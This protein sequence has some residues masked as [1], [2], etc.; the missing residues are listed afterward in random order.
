VDGHRPG[1][2]GGDPSGQ[3][4]DLEQVVR[5]TAHQRGV[6]PSLSSVGLLMSGGMVWPDLSKVVPSL[7]GESS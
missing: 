7:A 2:R 4:V 3:A 1:A 6:S 5:F